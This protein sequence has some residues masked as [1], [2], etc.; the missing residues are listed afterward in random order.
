MCDV[1]YCTS[2][3]LKM[4]IY[5]FNFTDKS[6]L[7]NDRNII[8]KTFC[9]I[10]RRSELVNS[11]FLALQRLKMLKTLRLLILNDALSYF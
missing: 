3:C 11:I 2:F 7:I 10:S 6:C 1:K 9:I 4:K 5:S 8:L